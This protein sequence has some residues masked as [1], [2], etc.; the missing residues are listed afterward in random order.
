MRMRARVTGRFRATAR[1][2]RIDWQAVRE[3]IDLAAVTTRLLGPPPGR[4]G[5]RSAHRL[6]WRCARGTHEDNNPSFSIKPG[7]RHWR[8]WRCGARGD[9]IEVMR[10]LKLPESCQP[11][12]PSTAS[13]RPRLSPSRRPASSSRRPDVPTTSPRTD[14]RAIP[15]RTGNAQLIVSQIPPIATI[16]PRIVS[17]TNPVPRPRRS[18]TRGPRPARSP[19]RRRRAR[20]R[21]APASRLSATTARIPASAWID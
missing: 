12:H 13:G 8:C 15:P 16:N 3:S 7:D 19:P 2:E 5:E 1:G 11:R 18:S 4:R 20:E 14:R 6:W 21:G 9:A 17:L 10:R